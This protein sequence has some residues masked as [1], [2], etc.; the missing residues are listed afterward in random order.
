MKGNEEGEKIHL[1][2]HHIFGPSLKDSL[3]PNFTLQTLQPSTLTSSK[4]F[5]QMIPTQGGKASFL[6]TR[7]KCLSL[8]QLPL[9]LVLGPSQF[10][11]V[12]TWNINL[13]L[14]VFLRTLSSV[15]IC[16]KNVGERKRAGSD[17]QGLSWDILDGYWSCFLRGDSA[18]EH[19]LKGMW[20]FQEL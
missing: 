19:R 4:T 9:H 2:V 1:G 15:I 5:S 10:L 6:P 8:I 11:A 13:Y 7:R 17:G 20:N 12:T 18:K 14:F 16:W 3:D